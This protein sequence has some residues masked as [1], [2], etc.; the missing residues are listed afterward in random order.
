M[1]RK[2]TLKRFTANYCVTRQDAVQRATPNYA[3]SDRSGKKRIILL[4]KRL[5]RRLT[6]RLTIKPCVID[7][8]VPPILIRIVFKSP[9]L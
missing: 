7:C 1:T 3:T 6:E 5:T 8:R 4:D 9:N 2:L